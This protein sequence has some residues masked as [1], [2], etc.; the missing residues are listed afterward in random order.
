MPKIPACPIEK[1]SHVRVSDDLDNR[2]LHK[3]YA[4]SSLSKAGHVQAFNLAFSGEKKRIENSKSRKVI[5]PKKHYIF[6]TKTA[7]IVIWLD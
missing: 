3:K 1:D 7:M 5:F 6:V 2:N 4:L